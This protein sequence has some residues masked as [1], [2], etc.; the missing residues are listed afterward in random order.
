[1]GVLRCS[2]GVLMRPAGVLMH[3]AGIMMRPAGV[4]MRPAGVLMRPAGI[5][6]RPAGVLMRPA[7]VLMRPAGVLMRPAGVLMRP[8][9]VLMRPA[10]VSVDLRE[11]KEIRGGRSSRDFEK[12]ADDPGTRKFNSNICF[13]LM[14]GQEFCLKTLSL[15]GERST[16]FNQF[17]EL[18]ADTNAVSLISSVVIVF[19]IP[20]KN[21]RK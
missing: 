20:K 10:G 5:M 6:M 7:G 2:A 15:V 8:A 4:L 1:M 9:G 14:Y 21:T 12:W 16:G 11:V 17:R 19:Q 13:V 3:P 18:R